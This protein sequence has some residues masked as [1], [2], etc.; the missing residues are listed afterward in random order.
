LFLNEFK[1]NACQE[2]TLKKVNNTAREGGNPPGRSNMRAE[3]MRE[4]EVVGMGAAV[5]AIGGDDF[6]EVDQPTGRIAVPA[7][8]NPAGFIMMVFVPPTAV[9]VQRNLGRLAGEY[10]HGALATVEAPQIEGFKTV[11]MSMPIAVVRKGNSAWTDNSN[12]VPNRLDIWIV[13]KNGEVTLFQ[14]GVVTHDNGA[15]FVLVGETA[16]K[17][18]LFDDSDYIVGVPDDP[19]YGAF[20]VRESI[21][22]NQEFKALVKSAKLWSWDGDEE[23]LAT[24]LGDIPQGYARIKWYKVFGGQQGQGIA[25]LPNGQDIW[26]HGADIDVT[27]DA[28]GIKRP[29]GFNTLITY[30]GIGQFGAKGGKKLLGVKVAQESALV[31][32]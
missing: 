10:G 13:G 25:V 12:Q 29:G 20:T 2:G 16:W 9:V 7:G 27:P 32:A 28:D 11:V 4:F 26:I 21:F 19:A 8:V 6:L 1:T 23:K 30:T 31:T 17:G 24:V 14:V 15:T 18:S 5:A 3:Q 22:E